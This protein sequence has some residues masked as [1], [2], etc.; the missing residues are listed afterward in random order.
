MTQKKE[1][2]TKRYCMFDNKISLFTS[3]GIMLLGKP[4]R[5]A[6]GVYDGM[7]LFICKYAEHYNDCQLGAIMLHGVFICMVLLPQWTI[8]FPHIVNTECI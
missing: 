4:K 5:Y 7:Y 1:F 8:L 6:Q 2:N 3:Y